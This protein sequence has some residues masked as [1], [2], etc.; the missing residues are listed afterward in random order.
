MQ[1]TNILHNIFIFLRPLNEYFACRQ[2]ITQ[3]SGDNLLPALRFQGGLYNF[4]S[5]VI[6]L[7]TKSCWY[8]EE[9]HLLQIRK[10]SNITKKRVAEIA[11]L[12]NQKLNKEL[13]QI[14][15][16]KKSFL[17]VYV[18]MYDCYEYIKIKHWSTITI[19]K[20]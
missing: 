18:G 4:G 11:I 16:A 6:N 7:F 2:Q 5:F 12:Q 13:H 3:Y 1:L 20:S 10:W 17:M 9:Q 19:L 8:V 15:Y 14:H